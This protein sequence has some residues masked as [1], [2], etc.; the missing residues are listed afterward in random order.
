MPFWIQWVYSTTADMLVDHCLNGLGQLVRDRASLGARLDDL[1]QADDWLRRSSRYCQ[2]GVQRS[3][4][5]E[6]LR[7]GLVGQR[8]DRLLDP[9]A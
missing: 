7:R 1:R 6:A 4:V 3:T 5:R 2:G 9:G 8:L